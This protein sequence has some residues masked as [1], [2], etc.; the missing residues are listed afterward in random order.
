MHNGLSQHLCI[1]KTL[2]LEQLQF[3]KGMSNENA[4]Y[5]LTQCIISLNQKDGILEQFSKN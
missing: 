2:L 5:K 4:A 1:N 3:R